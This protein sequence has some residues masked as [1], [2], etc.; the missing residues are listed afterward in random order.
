MHKITRG[1]T[2]AVQVLLLINHLVLIASGLFIADWQVYNQSFENYK[3]YFGA[4][5][6]LSQQLNAQLKWI[7]FIFA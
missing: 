1:V 3:P 6:L 4:Y 7:T 2:L 5:W